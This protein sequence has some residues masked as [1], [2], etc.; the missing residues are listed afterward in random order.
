MKTVS[1]AG[2][3]H[4]FPVPCWITERHAK[5]SMG[6]PDPNM[7]FDIEGHWSSGNFISLF[8]NNPGPQ[9][10]ASGQI[11][12]PLVSNT[13]MNQ[14]GDLLNIVL[15]DVRQDLEKLNDSVDESEDSD[16]DETVWH[17]KQLDPEDRVESWESRST[18]E[19]SWNILR[20]Y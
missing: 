18:S 4:D 17:S 15:P 6:H 14:L 13:T 19:I 3:F 12:H 20:F 10:S 5:L 16:M 1:K 9:A 7:I 2:F 11:F 8:Q